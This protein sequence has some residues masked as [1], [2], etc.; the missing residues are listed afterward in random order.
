MTAS[1]LLF[2][3][4]KRNVV[5]LWALFALPVLIALLPWSLGFRILKQ[6]ARLEFVH[7]T[8]VENAWHVAQAHLPGVDETRWKRR[9]RLLRLVE[10]V[11]TWLTLLRS[12]R[13]WQT[14]TRI[15]GVWPPAQQPWVLLTYHWGAGWWVW[16]PLRAH[17]IHAHFVARRA[18]AVDLGASRVALAYG[19]LRNRALIRIG[20][21]G[22]IFVGGGAERMIEALAANKS[23]VGMLDLPARAGQLAVRAPLL[24]GFVELPAGLARLAERN[25]IRVALFSCGLDF[26]TGSR[27]LRIEPLPPGLPIDEVMARYVAH[28]DQRLRE[29]PEAWQIWQEAGGMF[30]PGA[31]H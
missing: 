22:P 28:L 30:V 18:Q 29:A 14:H 31:E 15:D 9:F 8:S 19:K 17:G 24:D 4:A 13:W 25:G 23:L 1:A 7:R 5:D 2:D 27:D 26:A 11:D 16:M 12:A 10:R 6:F 21:L 20:S 3:R